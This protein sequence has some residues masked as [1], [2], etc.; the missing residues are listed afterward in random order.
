MAATGK[1]LARAELQHL[2]AFHALR[3]Q[4]VNELLLGAVFRNVVIAD[5]VGNGLA[6]LLAYGTERHLVF[7]QLLCTSEF[8]K[9]EQR[10]RL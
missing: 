9:P 6:Y 7:V 4:V 2:I 5:V 3:S 1:I 8:D 10:H